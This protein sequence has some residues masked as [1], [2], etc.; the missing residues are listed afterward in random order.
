MYHASC[1]AF[2]AYDLSSSQVMHR[3]LF[4]CRSIPKCPGTVSQLSPR[5]GATVWG[6]SPPSAWT[7]TGPAAAPLWLR[8]GEYSHDIGQSQRRICLGCVVLRDQRSVWETLNIK[9]YYVVHAIIIVWFNSLL[10]KTDVYVTLVFLNYLSLSNIAW[11]VWY[12]FLLKSEGCERI[13]P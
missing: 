7:P 2:V 1:R 8:P 13:L 12:G 9:R 5:A 6:L 10:P 4:C 11:L 3:F